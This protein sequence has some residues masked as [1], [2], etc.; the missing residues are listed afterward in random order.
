VECEMS[1]VEEIQLIINVFSAIAAMLASKIWLEASLIKIPPSTSDSCEGVGPFQNSLVQ[2][3][4][5]NKLAAAWTAVA[6]LCQGI[7]LS[8][9]AMAYLWHK[10]AA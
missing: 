2:S 7:A 9:G 5:K 6:A 3:A 4:R 8:V 10:L 1:K